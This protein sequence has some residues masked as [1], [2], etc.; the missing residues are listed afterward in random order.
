MTKKDALK[1][2]SEVENQI[3]KIYYNIM[4][5]NEISVYKEQ[6]LSTKLNLLAFKIESISNSIIYYKKLET[7]KIVKKIILTILLEIISFVMIFISLAVSLIMQPIILLSAVKIIGDYI[8]NDEEKLNARIIERLT[9]IRNIANNCDTF[10][11]A[12]ITKREERLSEQRMKLKAESL[13]VDLANEYLG[14]YINTGEL[15]EISDNIK[16][17]LIK[18]LQEDLE[19]EE[20]DLEALLSLASDKF[21]MKNLNEELKLNMILIKRKNNK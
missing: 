9:E 7:K 3:S 15:P 1:E 18:M 2:L 20:S 19:T 13:D 8:S 17:T 5:S 12:K 4:S 14:N 10:M 6:L 16:E 21:L 11:T